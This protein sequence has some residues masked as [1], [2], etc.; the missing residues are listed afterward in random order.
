MPPALPKGADW[1]K[2]SGAVTQMSAAAMLLLSTLNQV[3]L[4]EASAEPDDVEDRLA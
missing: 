4:Q 2:Q 1:L 3:F